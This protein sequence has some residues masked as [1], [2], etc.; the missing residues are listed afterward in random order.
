MYGAGSV[1]PHRFVR[2]GKTQEYFMVRYLRFSQRSFREF[3]S[4]WYD[5]LTFGESFVTILRHWIATKVS[6]VARR[7]SFILKVQADLLYSWWILYSFKYNQQDATFYN[8]C[9][10]LSVLCMFRAVSL[11]I[12]RSSRTVDTASGMC[13]ACLLLPLAASGSSKQ[14][15]H[16][17]DAVSTVLELPMMGGETARNM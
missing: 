11:P 10:L 7:H 13:Q 2:G 15:W 9:L 3:I 5:A 8:I 14:A 16:V 12:I 4:F 17:P 6:L 1:L